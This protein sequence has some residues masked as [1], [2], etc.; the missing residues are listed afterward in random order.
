MSQI[1]KDNLIT[2]IDKIYE[3]I[4][5]RYGYTNKHFTHFIKL[6]SPQYSS[7]ND[8][9]IAK[10][11]NSRLLIIIKTNLNDNYFNDLTQ[12]IYLTD[13]DIIET[14]QKNCNANYITSELEILISNIIQ[15]KIAN[16]IIFEISE[17]YFHSIGIN[18]KNSDDNDHN[19][20]TLNMGTKVHIN[21]LLFVLNFI[22]LKEQYSNNPNALKLQVNKFLTKLK[23]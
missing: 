12:P 15:K 6:K 23:S 22:L 7:T 11:N 20:I 8:F 1:S 21:D 16:N 3:N 18:Y 4:C 19:I 13:M 17:K 2:E 10:Q 9:L 5:Q 14:I